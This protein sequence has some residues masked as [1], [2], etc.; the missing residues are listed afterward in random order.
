[1]FLKILRF[2]GVLKVFGNPSEQFGDI[3]LKL[4]RPDSPVKIA[5]GSKNLT[6]VRQ[7]DKE[8]IIGPSSV[9]VNI[10][11]ERRGLSSDPVSIEIFIRICPSVR[12]L[13]VV[14]GCWLLHNS[15]LK[16]LRTRFNQV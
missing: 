12:W 14:V 9:Y 10:L 1:M 8:G 6:L 3:T 13:L 15:L 2:V 16:S 5:K 4:Q 7:L 11:C